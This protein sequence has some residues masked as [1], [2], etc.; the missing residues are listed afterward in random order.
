MLKSLEL[1]P[2]I[3]LAGAI[4]EWISRNI[5]I[6]VKTAV[7]CL[8]EEPVAVENIERILDGIYQ[9]SEDYP[10]CRYRVRNAGIVL[11]IVKLLR[12]CSKSIGTHLRSKALMTLFSMARDEESKV[13]FFQV[14]SLKFCNYELLLI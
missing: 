10:S 8:S 11:L 9:V 14:F 6:Q 5:E 3:G 1:K 2:N 13:S 7:Q 4:E 12:N